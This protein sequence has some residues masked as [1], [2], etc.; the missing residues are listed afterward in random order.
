MGL[1]I[2]LIILFFI[3]FTVFK[4]FQQIAK[5]QEEIKVPPSSPPGPVAETEPITDILKELGRRLEQ[6]GEVDTETVKPAGEPVFPY[7]GRIEKMQ[8][9]F[10]EPVP[11]E[12]PEIP[13]EAGFLPELEESVPDIIKPPD[14]INAVAPKKAKRQY[15][16]Q[17]GGPEVVKGIL[18]SEI[19]GPP[20][21]MRRE[22][23]IY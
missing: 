23:M 6:V 12:L 21:S 15:A 3:L 19:L 18:M 20:V 16:L 11:V 8:P 1:V 2:N 5:K 4:R 10:A 13:S 7:E 14:Y 17:F 9:E 22:R